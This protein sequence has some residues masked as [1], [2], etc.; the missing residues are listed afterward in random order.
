VDKNKKRNLGFCEVPEILCIRQ[1]MKIAGFSK[2]L[3]F[4]LINDKEI[5][6]IRFGEK[7]F[8]SKNDLSD[9]FFRELSGKY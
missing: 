3:L 8:I 4:K 5:R 1:L 6:E 7:I 2:K 9:W